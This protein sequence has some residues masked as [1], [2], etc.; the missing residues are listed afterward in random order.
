MRTIRFDVAENGKK[1]TPDETPVFSD[2]LP[3]YGAEFITE[4][5]IYPEGTLNGANG[6]NPVRAI[7]GGT[8]AYALARG[9]NRQS[10]LGFNQSNGVS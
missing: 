3:A 4:G 1:F 8:G 10:F 9:E 5:Y 2:G 7:T 6:V